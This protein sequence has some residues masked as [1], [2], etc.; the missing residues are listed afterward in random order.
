MEVKCSNKSIPSFKECGEVNPNEIRHKMLTDF[1][2]SVIASKRKHVIAMDIFKLRL[3]NTHRKL[4]KNAYR[5][6]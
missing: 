6:L 4:L 3:Y 5:R 2:K 1:D